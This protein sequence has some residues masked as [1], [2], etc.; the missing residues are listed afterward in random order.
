MLKSNLLLRY[1]F[2]FDSFNNVIL[3]E[4]MDIV[5]YYVVFGIEDKVKW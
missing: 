2:Y 5:S 3:D 4:N 1:Y